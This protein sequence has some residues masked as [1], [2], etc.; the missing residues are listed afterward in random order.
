MPGPP[1][2][3]CGAT[4]IDSVYHGYTYMLAHKIGLHLCRCGGCHGLRLI[5]L[6]MLQK[7]RESEERPIPARLVMPEVHA[8]VCPH[9][10]SKDFRR[11]RR[12]WY[13]RLALRPRMARCKQCGRR[14]PFPDS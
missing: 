4:K 12:H 5:R 6:S 11:S 14:F 3:R 8:S 1:C 13:E 9:C 2:V 7:L 10:G